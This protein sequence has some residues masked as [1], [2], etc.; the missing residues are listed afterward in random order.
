MSCACPRALTK[1]QEPGLFGR[2]GVR[3]VFVVV[4]ACSSLLCL[5]RTLT[6][7]PQDPWLF[8]RFGVRFMFVVVVACSSLWCLARARALTK[9]PQEP[10]LFGRFGVPF[11]FVVLSPVR[12]CC[13]LRAPALLD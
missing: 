12:R 11:L 10:W 9:E 3:F 1:D 6:K 4:V 13:V 7:E 2:F 8:G 5:A